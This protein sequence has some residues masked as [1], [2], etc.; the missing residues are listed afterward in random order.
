MHSVGMSSNGT[1]GGYFWCLRHRHV[2]TA[3][4]ACPENYRLGPYET[5][6]D[7]ERSLQTANDGRAVDDAR[8]AEEVS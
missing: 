6:A 2:E 3:S 7:A 5:E 1:G 4:V 8:S